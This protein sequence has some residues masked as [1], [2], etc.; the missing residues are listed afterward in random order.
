MEH[1]SIV[2]NPVSDGGRRAFRT[3]QLEIRKNSIY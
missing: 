2:E 1:W 3:A